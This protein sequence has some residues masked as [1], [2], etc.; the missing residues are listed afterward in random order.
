[1][2]DRANIAIKQPDGGRIW[3]YTHWRGYE[4]PEILQDAIK[5]APDRWTDY[6]YFARIV[7]DSMTQG[8]RSTTGFGITNHMGDNERPILVVD[9]D[10]CLITVENGIGHDTD[11]PAAKTFSF[12]A[13]AAIIDISWNTMSELT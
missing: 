11:K 10:K 3:L 9:C 5:R 7:F 8:D 4:T 1:M 13:F 12:E 6:Q 2:G